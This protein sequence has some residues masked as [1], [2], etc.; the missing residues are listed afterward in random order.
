MEDEQHSKDSRL[1]DT[2]RRMSRR[3]RAA[4]LRTIVQYLD[5]SDAHFLLELVKKKLS[6]DPLSELPSDVAA[7]VLRRI[8]DAT[9]LLHVAKVCKEW[10]RQVMVDDI[11][12]HHLRNMA[13]SRFAREKFK[14]SKTILEYIDVLKYE[15]ML[16]ANWQSANCSSKVTIPALGVGV[17]TC[18]Q[19]DEEEGWLI[20]GADNGNVGIWDINSG[21]CTALPPG[22]QGGVWTL[23]A[24]KDGILVTGSTDR[25]LMVWD[26]KSGNRLAELIGH[27]ST[28]R[29][30]EI[31]GKKFIVSGSRDGTLRVWDRLDGFSCLHVLTGHGGSVRCIV[32]FKDHYVIS[33]SYDHTLKV[34]DL[35]TGRCVS[36]C[37][38][39]D[40]KIYSLAATDEYVFSGGI[41]AKIRVWRPLTGECVDVFSDHSALVGLLDIYDDC[42][43]AGSTDGSISLWNI[44]TLRR[45]CFLELAHRSSITA[46]G[47]NRYSAIS[48]S[49]R[50]L[51]LWSLADMR[52]T[53]DPPEPLTLSDKADVVW[54]VVLGE[55]MAAIAY[56]Q[57][58]ITRI[59]LINFSP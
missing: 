40:G 56:Q 1:T 45:L 20:S 31:V 42:L 18:L 10:K 44:R 46:L 2:L 34:W 54:R 59:D 47:I 3:N 13:L 21:K 29:C 43:V 17:I 16:K 15:T 4:V 57:A 58:G 5:S 28:V 23:K 53:D 19:L 32:P 7:M 38:G 12:K 33:G 51:R 37:T 24:T 30:V 39:H 14:H 8:P 6:C 49:E 22:H 9:G 27:S 48:G 55:R 41:D 11:W 50:A 25:T 52:S 36:T 35:N 26:M